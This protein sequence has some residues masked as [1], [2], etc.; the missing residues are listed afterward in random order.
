M[1]F[2]LE[3]LRVGKPSPSSSRGVVIEKD[4]SIYELMFS[5]DFGV[6][7]KN[8]KEEPSVLFLKYNF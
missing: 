1:V 2:L 6:R 8:L 7:R 5:R 3:Q 4:G